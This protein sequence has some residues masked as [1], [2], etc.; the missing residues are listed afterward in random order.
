[1]YMS[2]DHGIAAQLLLGKLARIA[3]A[4]MVVYQHYAGKVPI[5]RD[6]C[7]QIGRELTFPLYDVRKSW[8]M[9]AAGVHPHTVQSLVEDF[10]LD[11]MVGAGG[12]VHGHPMGARAGARAF[13]QAVE[14]VT[15]GIPLEEAAAEYEE[16][17]V[18]IDT[19]KDPHKEHDL[20]E[21]RI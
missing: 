17:R 12:P 3:G 19:W 10:G 14:A 11:V 9:P 8:P 13:R 7:I 21:R 5:T 15:A 20:S 2:P 6:N 18:A 16:L 1:M 4:D